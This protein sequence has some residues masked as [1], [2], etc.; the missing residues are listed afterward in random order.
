[1]AVIKPSAV[2]APALVLLGIASVQLGAGFARKLF[3]ELPPSAVVTL[4]LATSSIVLVLISRPLLRAG[5]RRWRRGDLAVA[6]AFGVTLATM[7][8][9]I[10]ESFSRIP[11]GIAVT[12]EFLGPLGVAVA[13]SRRW[14]DLLWVGLAA[15]GVALLTLD[16]SGAVTAAGVAFALLAAA[17]WAGYILLSAETGRRFPGSSGLALASVAATMLVLPVGIT[18]GGTGLLRP[19]LLL[20]GAAIGLLSSVIPYT[21]ELEALRRMPARVFGILMSLEPAVAALVGLVILGE[22][23]DL[24]EWTAI[25][26]VVVACLGATRS[27]ETPREAPEA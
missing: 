21:F 4:R 3:E 8:Y 16:D 11:L 26:C 10:Y 13:F 17:A 19:D 25:G 14:I 2:P 22:M 27:Q 12:I 15:A 18:T 7:N 1:M 6:G 23:L 5:A 9:S 20:I 24:R